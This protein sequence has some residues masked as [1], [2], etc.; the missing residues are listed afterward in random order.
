MALL[1]SSWFW[2]LPLSSKS[3]WHVPSTQRK[4]K[5]TM[6]IQIYP[7]DTVWCP[8]MSDPMMWILDPYFSNFSICRGKIYVLSLL[9]PACQVL[10][11]TSRR[12]MDPVLREAKQRWWLERLNVILLFC[13]AV[14]F[15][16]GATSPSPS[17]DSQAG[18]LWMEFSETKK[19]WRLILMFWYVMLRICWQ[20]WSWQC[21]NIHHRNT[22]GKSSMS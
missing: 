19:E 12:G 16:I 18:Y 21:K 22:Q 4:V 3:G 17:W 13:L 10:H 5:V 14:R 8:L 15:G 7:G 2:P 20:I 11:Y 9:L 1:V 6:A